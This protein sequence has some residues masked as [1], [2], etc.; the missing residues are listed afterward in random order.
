M[1]GSV[2]FGFESREQYEQTLRLPLGKEWQ[3][4]NTHRKLVAPKIVKKMGRI[5]APPK[6]K[7]FE[8]QEKAKEGGAKTNKKKKASNTNRKKL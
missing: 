8:Q 3:S 1:L 7:N 4:A 2:P 6:F 5:I